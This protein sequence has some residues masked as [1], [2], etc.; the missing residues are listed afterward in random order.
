MKMYKVF[1]NL[2]SK[3][4]RMP[5]NTPLGFVYIHKDNT[6]GVVISIS[7]RAYKEIKAC[8][9]TRLSITKLA[10]NQFK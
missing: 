8:K 3:L 2:D 4:I 9:E 10:F 5:S 7:K 6:V 1:I